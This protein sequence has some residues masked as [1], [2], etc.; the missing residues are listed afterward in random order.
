MSSTMDMWTDKRLRPYMAVTGHW[1]E[2]KV[3]QT[4]SGPQY[5]LTLRSALIGFI[6]V[7]GHH[8]GEHLAHAFLHVLERIHA[9]KRVSLTV[10][11]DYVR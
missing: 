8:D 11:S 3:I 6:C 5:A 10:C 2:V 4:P 9:A 1:I 7:P